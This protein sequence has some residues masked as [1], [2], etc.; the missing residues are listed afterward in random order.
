LKEIINLEIKLQVAEGSLTHSTAGILPIKLSITMDGIGG[1]RIGDVFKIPESSLPI[2]YK[3]FSTKNRIGFIV[4]RLSHSLQNNDWLTQ[5]ETQ[6][7]ILDEKGSY[8]AVKKSK[9]YEYAPFITQYV[10]LMDYIQK[11]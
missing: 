2:G 9:V 8:S 3:G 5:I 6:T 7:V 1:I 10:P 4:T 11:Q